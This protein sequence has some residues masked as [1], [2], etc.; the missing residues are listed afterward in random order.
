MLHVLVHDF[1]Q[2]TDFL[3]GLSKHGHH[4]EVV[5]HVE[6][7]QDWQSDLQHRIGYLAFMGKT[8]LQSAG[9]HRDAP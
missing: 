4:V 6:G 7:E 1:E 9:R 3:P 8:V 5:H 2:Q